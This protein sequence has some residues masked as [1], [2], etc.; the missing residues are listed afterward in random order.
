[1]GLHGW[2]KTSGSRGMHINVRIQPRWTFAE[3]RRAAV[4]LSRAVERRLQPER[5]GS[6]HLLRLLRPPAPRRSRVHTPQLA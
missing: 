3:V 5:Q 1:M 4:A 6:H 2:P